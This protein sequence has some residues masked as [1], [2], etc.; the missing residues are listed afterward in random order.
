MSTPLLSLGPQ[1][2]L[3]EE[4]LKNIRKGY[5]SYKH[6]VDDDSTSLKGADFEDILGYVE[7]LLRQVN[8]LENKV[9]GNI[10]YQGVF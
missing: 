5:D 9:T 3:N 8:F 1:P 7:R 2:P 10:L 6:E 4:D